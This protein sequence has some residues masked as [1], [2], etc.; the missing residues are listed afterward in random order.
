MKRVKESKIQFKL[1][2]FTEYTENSLDT[3]RDT[4]YLAPLGLK[5]IVEANTV[6]EIPRKTIA[7]KIAW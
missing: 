3:A 4:A 5:T 6:I 1:V 2:Y 7:K